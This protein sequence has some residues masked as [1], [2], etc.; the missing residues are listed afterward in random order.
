MTDRSRAKDRR[1]EDGF[2]DRLR[3]QAAARQQAW[4]NWL[5]RAVQRRASNDAKG[6]LSAAP[7]KHPFAARDDDAG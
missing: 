6:G 3:E 7:G 2:A 5:T 1:T 4:E